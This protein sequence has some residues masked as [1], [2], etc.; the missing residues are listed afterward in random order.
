MKNL[1]KENTPQTFW[2]TSP[3]IADEIWFQAVEKSVSALNL[4]KELSD[5]DQ[6]YAMTLGE[7]QFGDDRYDLGSM[8]RLYYELKP[9]LPRFVINILKKLNSSMTTDEFLLNWPEEDKYIQ[10]QWET[11]K[12]VLDISGK[13][14]LQFM[15]F[16]PEGKRFAFTLTHDIES[17]KGQSF[18]R[19]V[20]DLEEEL[21]FRSSFNFVPEKYRLD[22]ELMEELRNRGF[23]IGVHGLK[24]DGK[25]FSN[26]DE[27]Y[28]RA[29]KINNY[30]NDF[31]A[32]GFRSPLCHR[33]PEWMQALN[34]EYDL[35]FFDTDPFEPILG[36]SMSIW[37]YKLGKFIELPYTLVQD[38][39]LRY[40]LEKSEPDLW[41]DKVN[42]IEKYYGMAL[43]NSHPDY[44]QDSTLFEIYKNFLIGVKEKGNYWHALP[45]EVAAW[46]KDRMSGTS[47]QNV[48]RAKLGDIK[49]DQGIVQ[50]K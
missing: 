27:F 6:I 30:L 16:W 7:E 28:R 41:L 25:L 44:L 9:L 3:A 12:N 46:W 20:A 37:P 13:T 18:V 35:S 34:V 42:F 11:L 5:L 49:F 21:G 47:M 23:E 26:K 15:H 40:T 22:F 31:G 45:N 39:T 17:E 29:E 14:D 33:N 36:G 2:Q 4:Q 38:S 32:V 19:N 24:H 10:F 48:H 50:I 43:L 1:W 8:K